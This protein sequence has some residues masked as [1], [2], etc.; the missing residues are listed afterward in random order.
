[1]RIMSQS[2]QDLHTHYQM[3]FWKCHEMKQFVSIV[4][5]ATSYTMKS[6]CW[7]ID[8]ELQNRNRRNIVGLRKQSKI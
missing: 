6:N 5:S 8:F 7:K 1:M 2:M 4:V 3:R